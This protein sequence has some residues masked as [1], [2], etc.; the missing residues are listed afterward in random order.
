M[1]DPIFKDEPNEWWKLS[2]DVRRRW[3]TETDY[4]TKPPSPELVQLVRDKLSPPTAV[5]AVESD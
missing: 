2:I 1:T 3:W 5:V 4:G